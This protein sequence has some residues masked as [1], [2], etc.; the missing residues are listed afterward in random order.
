MS[1]AIFVL[2]AIGLGLVGW[3]AAR[4]RAWAFSARRDDRPHSLPSYH[5]WYV[6]L[7]AFVPAVVFA[8]VWNIVS[9]QLVLQA[10]LSDPAAAKL[11]EFGIVR[12][13]AIAEAMAVARGGAQGVFNP[14]AT[15]LI[16]PATNAMH[17]YGV[18]GIVLTLI[19][20][21]AG[22]AF[23][24]LRIK[25]DFTART[26]VERA[27]M[28]GL[29]LASL[30]AILTTFGILASLIFETIRFFGMVNPLDFLFGTHWAPNPMGNPAYTDSNDYGA[31]PLFWGTIYIGAII[32][33]IVAIPLGLIARST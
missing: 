14:L 10:I 19:V 33:M 3:L 32:A 9:P 13:S 22:G 27:V 17:R 23:A 30:V 2:I 11:P 15:A 1:P 5:G 8:I 12:D 24:F 28:L 16:D 26:R 7:W 20:G 18:I 6:A 25:P 29:L 21:F 31:L 4:S